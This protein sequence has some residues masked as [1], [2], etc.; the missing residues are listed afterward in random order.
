MKSIKLLTDSTS[1]LPPALLEQHDIGIIAMYVNI[2]TASYSDLTVSK[3]E[4]YA[5]LKDAN[6]RPTSAAQAPGD[7]QVAIEA[8]LEEAERVI[9]LHLASN[10]SG[11]LSATEV[12]MQN[13]PRERVTVWNSGTLSMGLGWQV[14]A[15][16]EAIEA[17]ADYETVMQVLQDVRSRTKV[18]AVLDDFDNLRRSGR[19]SWL[20][21]SLGQLLQIKPILYAVDNQVTS[22][23]RVRTFGKALATLE[24][25]G[26]AEAPLERLAILHT[27]DPETAQLVHKRLADI[28]PADYTYITDVAAS[29]S[30]H[31]GQ[32]VIGL[33][34]VA[35]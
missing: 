5:R 23:A 20:Q 1:D 18:W 13:L 29:T 8:A 2:G 21:A 16:A 4:F 35:G 9:V 12:A 11:A 10:M 17:G 30:T 28:A 27:R 6:P 24:A 26:R 22:A 7:S 32:G 33:A 3:D 14:L 19:V 34:T 15:A 25:L 31:L